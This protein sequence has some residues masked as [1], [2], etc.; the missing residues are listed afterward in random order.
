[1]PELNPGMDEWQHTAVEETQE[2]C[3]YR[4]ML[5]NECTTHL[6]KIPSLLIADLMSGFIAAEAAPPVPSVN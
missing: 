2:P 3:G 1:M 5:F 4:E 6:Y